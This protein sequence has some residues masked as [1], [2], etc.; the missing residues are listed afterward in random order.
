MRLQLTTAMKNNHI[1]NSY[2]N[3]MIIIR[4][5]TMKPNKKLTND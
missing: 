4:E 2:I 5:I 3:D 1:Y